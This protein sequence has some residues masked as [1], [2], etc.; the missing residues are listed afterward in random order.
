MLGLGGKGDTALMGPIVK[1]SKQMTRGKGNEDSF[2]FFELPVLSGHASS[3]A[4][5][6]LPDPKPKSTFPSC[7]TPYGPLEVL[8][9]APALP[10]CSAK[11][12]SSPAY[13]L[14]VPLVPLDRSQSLPD[15]PMELSP[16]VPSIPFSPRLPPQAAD[17]LIT[18][19][20][21]LSSMAFFRSIAESRSSRPLISC[22]KE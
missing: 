14:P 1:W 8:H 21:A 19:R 10:L 4:N 18:A 6:D 2:D 7:T 15:K 20:N 16:F 13:K 22:I 12:F 9:L 5:F 3:P 17:V 11:R